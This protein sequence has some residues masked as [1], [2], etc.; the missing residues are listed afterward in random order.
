[1]VQPFKGYGVDGLITIVQDI[2]IIDYTYVLYVFQC[3]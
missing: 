3:K 2:V 1:M